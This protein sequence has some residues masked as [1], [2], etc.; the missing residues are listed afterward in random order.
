LPLKPYSPELLA[1]RWGCSAEKVRQMYHRG[2]LAGFRLGKLIRI[3][4]LE[5]E[6]FECAQ[7]QAP[8]DTI[9]SNTAANSPSL[10]GAERTAAEF[11]LARMIRG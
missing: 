7:L 10:L 1:D 11:R 5:V 2:E 9:S 4:A 8:K 3:P 6:R